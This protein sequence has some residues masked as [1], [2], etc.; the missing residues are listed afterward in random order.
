MGNKFFKQKSGLVLENTS[1]AID[2]LNLQSRESL[3]QEQ[4]VTMRLET[5]S[6]EVRELSKE[7]KRCSTTKSE[8]KIK[9]YHHST[10]RK[11]REVP[12]EF[13]PSRAYSVR[14]PVLN[15][16]YISGHLSSQ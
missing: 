3:L 1:H 10:L 12:Y 5:L 2:L 6:K 9:P 16:D 15:Q 8:N 11:D 14:N 13:K 7:I 4:K